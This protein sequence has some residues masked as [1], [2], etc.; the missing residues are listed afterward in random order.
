MV[1]DAQ[2]KRTAEKKGRESRPQKK[3]Q[4]APAVSFVGMI[5][6]GSKGRAAES[7]RNLSL[8]RKTPLQAR[9]NKSVIMGGA[10]IFSK[11]PEFN[12]KTPRREKRSRPV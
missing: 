7:R 10:R 9:R 3:A 8:P 5:R 2:P 4:S 6:P 12:A 11:L 1:D